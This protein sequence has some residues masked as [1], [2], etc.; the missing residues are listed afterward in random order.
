MKCCW[1]DLLLFDLCVASNTTLRGF[2]LSSRLRSDEWTIIYK[3]DSNR[4]TKSY[5]SLLALQ[6]KK[7]RYKSLVWNLGTKIFSYYITHL[8]GNICSINTFI[9][10]IN[11]DQ[12]H[13]SFPTEQHLPLTRVH[14]LHN[15]HTCTCK[16]SF[17]QNNCGEIKHTPC[18]QCYSR[19]SSESSW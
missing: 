14:D 4:V 10:L 16:S 2:Y 8:H 17:F 7:Y 1:F 19:E 18:A 6:N 11:H 15:L 5:F 13:I 9:R 3:L 12:K